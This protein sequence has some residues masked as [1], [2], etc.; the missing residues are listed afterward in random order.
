MG[1]QQG[2]TGGDSTPDLQSSSPGINSGNVYT[3]TP[4]KFIVEGKAF[5]IHAALVLHHSKRLAR[6]MNGDLSDV[7]EEHAILKEVDAGTFGRF[8]EWV[9]KG[10][11]TW[12][13]VINRSLDESTSEKSLEDNGESE[14]RMESPSDRPGPTGQGSSVGF[15]PPPRVESKNWKASYLNP[16]AE[17]SARKQLKDFLE[18]PKAVVRPEN[19]GVTIPVPNQSPQEDYTEVFLSHARLYVFAEKYDVQTLKQ[20]ALEN[21]RASLVVF[22]LY[23]ERTGDIIAL[24]RYVYANTS[25]PIDGVEDLRTLLTHLMG[26]EMETL[27]QDKELQ[28]LLLANK[29]P[30][31]ADFLRMVGERMGQEQA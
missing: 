17:V 25:E 22:T 30:M 27:M 14:K 16:S 18:Q 1:K 31:L 4:F 28:A 23:K 15:V 24:L 6:M 9:Y 20:Q 3:S 21:L 2:R 19:P 13:G 26:Y 7:E 12:G 29:G 8:A 10:Y 11:Y 5:Y